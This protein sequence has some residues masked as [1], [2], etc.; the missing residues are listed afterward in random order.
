MQMSIQRAMQGE[1]QGMTQ[2]KM[3]I[4]REFEIAACQRV[5]KAPN[6][7]IPHLLA[8]KTNPITHF[9]ELLPTTRSPEPL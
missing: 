6:L 5:A 3:R 7:P 4:A 9:P 1:T 8:S 2:R